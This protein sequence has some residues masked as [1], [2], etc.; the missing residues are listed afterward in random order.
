MLPSHYT[1]ADEMV[2]HVFGRL[3]VLRQATSDRHGKRRWQCRC[4][5]GRI[6]ETNASSLRRGLSRS[7]GCLQR[8]ATVRNNLKHGL[9]VRTAKHPLIGVWASMIQRCTNPKSKDWKNY[10]A[11]GITVCARW[12][13]EGG[14]KNFV[15]DMG[16][17]PVRL[18]LERRN[19]DAGY[20]PS[21]C[22][23]ATRIEQRHNRRDS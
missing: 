2:G 6:V 1:T 22:S 19:N 13:G 18:T 12:L 7:C 9:L 11:R 10:G 21:N 16:P 14:F 23:W 4:E 15:E 8:E 17:R 3:V 5:C 20:S